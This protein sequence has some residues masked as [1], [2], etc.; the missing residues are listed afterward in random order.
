MGAHFPLSLLAFFLPKPKSKQEKRAQTCR[1]IGGAVSAF[2]DKTEL[3]EDFGSSRKCR[4][5]KPA[6][7]P[8]V[9][10]TLLEIK[11]APSKERLIFRIFAKNF[12]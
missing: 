8:S 10:K 7:S 12:Q 4:S 1:S 5:A 11:Q 6:P 2:F 3:E 9:S